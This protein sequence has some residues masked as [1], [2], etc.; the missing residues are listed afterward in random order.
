MSVPQSAGGDSG[1]PPG[2]GRGGSSRARGAFRIDRI[3]DAV[4]TRQPAYA[5]RDEPYW[6][7]A[8]AIVLR[9]DP[10][11]PSMLF[12]QRAVHE[13]DPWS[14]QIG[15]PGGRR[16]SGEIDLIE[17]VVRETREETGIDL[18]AQGEVFG[19]LDELRPRTPT[20]PPFI[21]RPYVARVSGDPGIT[22]SDE[23]A[24]H[25]WAP[26]TAIFDPANT[27]P[28]RVTSHH[29]AMWRDAIHYE[30]RVIWGLTER[31][32]RAFDAVVR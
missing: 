12:V 21:V 27:R 9:D 24:D 28:S 17:T 2:A 13:G 23:L 30:G 16:D 20:L 1:R 10:A 26:L 7:A 25:F 8:V 11:G 29:V 4:R 19:P 32:L 14:G 31:I 22:L 6:E 18:R 15:L 3:A 5:E